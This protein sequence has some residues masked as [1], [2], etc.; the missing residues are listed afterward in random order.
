MKERD[1]EEF[2]LRILED[3]SIALCSLT[4]K[5][6][7]HWDLKPDNFM[8]NVKTEGFEYNKKEHKN[9]AFFKQIV[10]GE[11]E[12]EIVLIDYGLVWAISKDEISKEI[13]KKG[14][15]KY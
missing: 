12:Y 1:K 14:C 8:I 11:L 3:M 15:T 7:I 10:N 5:D 13:S 2:A 6:I 4:E 9:K